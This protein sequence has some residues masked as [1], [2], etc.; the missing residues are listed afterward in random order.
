MG[1]VAYWRGCAKTV[2]TVPE[3][4]SVKGACNGRVYCAVQ[5]FVYSCASV[6]KLVLNVVLAAAGC[7]LWQVCS[8]EHQGASHPQGPS[9]SRQHILQAQQHQGAAKAEH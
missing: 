2:L 8:L 3:R 9:S 5:G 6:L 4:L 7:Q 1:V